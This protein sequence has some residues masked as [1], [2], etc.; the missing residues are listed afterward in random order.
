MLIDCNLYGKE[1]LEYAT[2]SEG[3]ADNCVLKVE[4]LVDGRFKV[5]EMCDEWAMA[6]LTADQLRAWGH[7]LIN[8]A[9]MEDERKEKNK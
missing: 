4:R 7:E 5:I 9:N 6:F 1:P 3:L 2:V 8:M